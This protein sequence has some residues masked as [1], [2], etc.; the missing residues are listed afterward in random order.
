M[1]KKFRWY[2]ARLLVGKNQVIE[3]GH[4]CVVLSTLVPSV[5][6][7][8]ITATP[9]LDGAPVIEGNVFRP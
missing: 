4:A 6:V 7:G 3:P 5:S 1:I 2:L 9:D 8:K